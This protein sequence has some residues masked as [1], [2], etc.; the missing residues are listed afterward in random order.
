MSFD[1]IITKNG[2]CNGYEF[3]KNHRIPVWEIAE[4]YSKGKSINEIKQEKPVLTEAEIQNVIKYYKENKV[5]ID[6]QI[7]NNRA[8]E[9]AQKYNIRGDKY[10]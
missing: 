3:I 2:I 5:K 9:I 4:L 1:D 8:S 7:E 6:V 10:G